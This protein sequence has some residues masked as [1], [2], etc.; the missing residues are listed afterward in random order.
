[1]LQTCRELGGEGLERTAD[2]STISRGAAYECAHLCAAE[3]IPGFVEENGLAAAWERLSPEFQRCLATL[4]PEVLA[5]L[6]ALFSGAPRQ[7]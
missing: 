3:E 6:E 4:P 1:M 5:A 2:Y 7:P